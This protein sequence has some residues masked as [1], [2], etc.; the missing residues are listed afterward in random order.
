MMSTATNATI[1]GPAPFVASGE[2]LESEG[3]TYQIRRL[4]LSDMFRLAGICSSII[5][6]GTVAFAKWL[7]DMRAAPSEVFMSIVM[8]GLEGGEE[9]VLGALASMIG[10]PDPEQPGKFIPISLADL[11]NPG[12]FPVSSALDL[13][14]KLTEHPDIKAFFSNWER[15]KP[16]LEELMAK[17]QPPAAKQP[18]PE[19]SA[20]AESS[21]QPEPITSPAP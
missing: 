9:T 15:M 17:M 16:R 10:L 3:V 20:D 14:D 12:L 11:Q 18:E 19:P 7:Q 13:V 2:I 1:K 8:L 6:N 5:A 4:G 21:A